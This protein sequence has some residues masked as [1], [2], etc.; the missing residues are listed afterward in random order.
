MDRY[1]YPAVFD[2]CKE[3]GYCITFPDLS[4]IVTEGD[5][6]EESLAMAKEALTLHLWGMEDA[7]DHIPPPTPPEKVPVPE[8]GFVS[9]VEAWMP[10]IR[11]RMDNKAVNKMVT[12]PKWLKDLGDRENVNFSHILQ[13]ALKNHLGLKDYKQVRKQP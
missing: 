10:P 3:G 8:G 11:D 7:G 2:P 5:T 12:L 13:N 6:V 9:L 4:G 1:I